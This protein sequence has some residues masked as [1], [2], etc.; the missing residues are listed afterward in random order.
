MTHKGMFEDAIELE[1][2]KSRLKDEKERRQ[3]AEQ[4]V[5]NIKKEMRNGL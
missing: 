1:K 5:T 4:E 2:L 3:F